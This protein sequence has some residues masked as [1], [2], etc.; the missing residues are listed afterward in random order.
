[1]AI[2]L[3]ANEDGRKRF[4]VCLLVVF[5]LAMNAVDRFAYFMVGFADGRLMR[6]IAISMGG[7]VVSQFVLLSIWVTLGDRA[8]IRRLLFLVWA[9]SAMGAA[10]IL[11]LVNTFDERVVLLQRDEIYVLGTFPIVFLAACLPLTTFRCFFFRGRLLQLGSH[12]SV[13]QSQQQD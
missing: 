5:C 8:L 6:L 9:W 12:P 3:M 4:A 10:W 11:G 1:M 13:L 2:G 7:I